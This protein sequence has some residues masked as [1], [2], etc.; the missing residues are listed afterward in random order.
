LDPSNI[1]PISRVVRTEHGTAS[2]PEV[3]NVEENQMKADLRDPFTPLSA[4]P[5][6]DPP[7]SG[8]DNTKSGNLKEPVQP[9]KKD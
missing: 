4:D 2:I 7:Q 6:P 8:T 9:P 1:F 3:A 5:P